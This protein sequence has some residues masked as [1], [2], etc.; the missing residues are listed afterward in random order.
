VSS[1]DAR[2]GDI[3]EVPLFPN[4]AI[5]LHSTVTALCPTD[6]SRATSG[7]IVDARSPTRARAVQQP[8][9]EVCLAIYRTVKAFQ[10][11]DDF[12]LLEATDLRRRFG[13][14]KYEEFAQTL[15]HLSQLGLILVSKWVLGAFVSYPTNLT[16]QEFFGAG[17]INIRLTEQGLTH[18]RSL[19]RSSDRP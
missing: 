13:L 11:K 12:W 6:T 14:R 17:Q 10:K 16:D 18:F 9:Q 15:I 4:P 2:E 3:A 7:N 8:P 5:I 1:P 19:E